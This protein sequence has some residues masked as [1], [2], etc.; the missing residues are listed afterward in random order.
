MFCGS[1]GQAMIAPRII[2]FHSVKNSS[3]IN[4]SEVFLTSAGWEPLT[5]L[6]CIL[7]SRGKANSETS[8][9]HRNGEKRTKKSSASETERG[10]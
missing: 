7:P 1:N 8:K 2:F 9:E 10:N 6:V 4:S 3:I 5:P